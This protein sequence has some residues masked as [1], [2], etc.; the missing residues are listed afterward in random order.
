M[1]IHKSVTESRVHQLAK[2]SMFGLESLGV[3]LAC[4]EE[5]DQVEPD[6]EGY[7]CQ[8]CDEPQVFGAEQLLMMETFYA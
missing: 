4:G 2:Q 8:V 1:R 6:A 3:C 7:T 5:A